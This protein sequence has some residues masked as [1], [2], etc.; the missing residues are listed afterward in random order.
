MAPKF[1]D[2]KDKKEV[3]KPRHLEDWTNSL[4]N[5]LKRTPKASGPKNATTTDEKVKVK[6]KV[7]E[8]KRPANLENWT[9]SID[10]VLK[11]PEG[12]QA[13][14]KFLQ[15]AEVNKRELTKELDF[16][17]ECENYCNE[18]QKMEDHA[19]HIF[20]TY[21]QIDAELEVGVGDA[22]DR[23]EEELDK[24]KKQKNKEI[25]AEAQKKIKEKLE[26]CQYKNFLDHLK[27]VYNL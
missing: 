11:D 12:I 22:A 27:K 4:D 8:Q 25:F 10:N 16:W 24:M 17:E 14:R 26:E 20:D 5:V 7:N 18:Y 23:V 2:K 1:K 9:K 15:E 13:F 6:T 3:K 19:A 21:L